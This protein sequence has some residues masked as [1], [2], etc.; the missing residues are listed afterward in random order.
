MFVERLLRLNEGPVIGAFEAANFHA[1]M[2]RQHG[3]RTIIGPVVIDEVLLD[4]LI[5]MTE[6]MGQQ[7]HVV[8]AQ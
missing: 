5:I 3:Q 7:A 2:G 1:R 6:E 8:P 4:D